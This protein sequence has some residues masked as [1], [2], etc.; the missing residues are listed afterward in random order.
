MS[1][2]NSNVMNH[3]DVDPISLSKISS[4][5]C[6]FTLIDSIGRTFEYDAWSWLGYLLHTDNYIHPVWGTDLSQQDNYNIFS[7]CHIDF[8]K[9]MNQPELY[10]YMLEDCTSTKLKKQ[11]HYDMDGNLV[12][13]KILPVSPIYRFETIERSSKYEKTFT[14][15]VH[16]TAM[17]HYKLIDVFNQVIGTYKL[18]L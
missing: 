18:Y 7:A 11:K 12:S 3:D 16:C 14:S 4:I 9:N 17:I 2:T 13:V 6:T 15:N 10:R 5:D 8:Q 1:N